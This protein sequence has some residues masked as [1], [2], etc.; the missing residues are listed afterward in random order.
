M[1]MI[2]PNPR[3][4]WPALPFPEWKETCATLH[5]WTQIVG[6]IRL[7]LSPWT[8]HSW[9]V[10]LYVTARGLTTSLV[11]I[12]NILFQIDF[13]FVEHIVRI[14]T[15]DGREKNVRLVPKSVAQFYAEL[16]S[17]L[18]E[19]NITVE[20]NTTPNEVD[21]AIPFEKN[22]TNAAYDPKYARRFWQIL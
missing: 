14:Q 11:P 4:I 13:D 7:S 18:R 17:A 19:L 8:N 12:G 6:K 1:A 5:M 16:M 15:S 10:T 9:H 3:D 20:I 22:E 21:P 2:E